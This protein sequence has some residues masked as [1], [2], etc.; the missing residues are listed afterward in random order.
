MKTFEVIV[1]FGSVN[2]DIEAE[3]EEQARTKAYDM[4][5]KYIRDQEVEIDQI[6]V[7]EAEPYDNTADQVYK[8]DHCGGR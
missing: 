7:E 2:W 3:D 5:V 1:D 4:A 8:Q 6:L